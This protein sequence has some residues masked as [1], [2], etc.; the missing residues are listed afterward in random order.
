VDHP[1]S[2]KTGYR[3]SFPGVTRPGRSV[4]HPPSN[5]EVKERVLL[6]HWVV[7]ACSTMNF[8]FHIS[9]NKSFLSSVQKFFENTYQKNN[10]NH[11]E[12]K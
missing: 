2:C 4:G 11:V 12:T 5:A 10:M 6:R 1:A 8:T 3:L 9:K 7:M